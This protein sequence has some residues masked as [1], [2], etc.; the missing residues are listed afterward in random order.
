[1]RRPWLLLATIAWLALPA[2]A[3][4][5]LGLGKMWTFERPPVGWLQREYGFTPDQ[6]WWDRLRLASLRVPRIGSASFVS[7]EG[8]VLTNHH[9]LR[10]YVGS[11]QGAN[12][13]GRD[14]FV[15]KELD[16]EVKLPKLALQRLVRW[17]DVTARVEAGV[18][19]TSDPLAAA[20]R[21]AAN[22]ERIAAEARAAAPELE[23]QVVKLFH[24]ALWQLYQFEVFDDVRLVMMPHL[25]IAHFGGDPDNFTF[26]RYS[27][28]FAFCRVWKDGA[29]LDTSATHFPWGDG[30]EDG[31][32]VFLTGNPGGTQRLWTR[33]QLEFQRDVRYPRV[34]E[35]L[36]SR[37]AILREFAAKDE[38]AEKRLLPSILYLENGQKLYRGE[39]S[40]LL[41]PSFVARKESAEAMFRQRVAKFDHGAELVVWDRMAEV[42]RDKRDLELPLHFQTPGGLPLLLRALDVVAFAANADSKLAQRA[43]DSDC[44]A[45]PVQQALFVDHL[46]RARR[47]LPAKD[48]YLDAVLGGLEPGPAV[49]QLLA[50]TRLC[51]ALVLE[52]LLAGGKPA[53]EAS[54]DPAIAVARMLSRLMAQNKQREAAIA[55]R[56]GD[57]MR[58]LGKLLREIYGDEVAADA[59]ATPRWSDGRVRG[60]PYNGTLAPW[61]TVM[62][63]LFARS[64]EFD[65]KHPFDL[66]PQWL[67]ARDRL[68][69]LASVNFVCTVDS[70]GGNSGSP[71]L[72]QR[73]ELTGLLFDGNIES[74]ANQFLFG[75]RVERSVCVHPQA[76][77]EALRKV[78]GA[79][80]LVREL[81]R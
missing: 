38:A 80:R 30:P 3:Q 21:R 2:A 81:A 5:E 67:A 61:R 27:L 24:G 69:M 13:W 17:T 57:L 25:Q 39:H 53:I 6:A 7:P 28:D 22:C 14:G 66:P 40:A 8:L 68:D 33:A 62:Q 18:E 60:Y 41:D 42:M 49:Q 48:P 35:L 70:T 76:I 19:P 46:I 63:G 55:A 34:R 79:K 72:N 43:R 51:E 10:E 47:H 77:V 78:Y 36:D 44:G 11:V 56:E 37:V 52:Q 32:A 54:R 31:Q 29:P 15:A 45:D 75:E 65:G 73:L 20:E 26:P 4:D 74:L 71:V 23:P 64:A 16:D 1:M 59:T 12:D 58:R 9:C 50:T